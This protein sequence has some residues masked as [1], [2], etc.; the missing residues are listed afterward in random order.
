MATLV[1]LVGTATHPFRLSAIDC[2]YDCRDSI[3]LLN[4]NRIRRA[5]EMVKRYKWRVFSRFREKREEWY[6]L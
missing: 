5:G 4:L 6:R 2:L 1:E 3:V